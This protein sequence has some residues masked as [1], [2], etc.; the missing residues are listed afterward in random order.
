VTGDDYEVDAEETATTAGLPKL[1]A[2]VADGSKYSP[3]DPRRVVIPPGAAR[4][5]HR[6]PGGDPVV[7]QL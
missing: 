2:V 5:A 4:R 6:L 1:S 3:R 7:T